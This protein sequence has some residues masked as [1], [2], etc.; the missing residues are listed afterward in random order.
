VSAV[1]PTYNRA[2]LLPQALDSVLHQTRPPDRVIVVDDGSTDGTE[3]VLS[4]YGQKIE[5]LS[6]PNS[7]KSTAL[8][9][10]LQAIDGGWVWLFDDDDLA[11]PDAIDLHLARLSETP[12]AFF[13]FSARTDLFTDH[14]GNVQACKTVELP[15]FPEHE[16]LPALLEN[17]FFS[18]QGAL[19]H[20]SCFKQIRFREDLYR[21]MDYEFMLRLVRR[22]PGVRLDR[23]TFY[24]R[25]HAGLRG[26]ASAR[27]AVSDVSQH[28]H[29][30]EQQFFS[31]LYHELDLA[32]YVGAPTQD[33]SAEVAD[34]QP[35]AR[36]KRGTV[37]ARKGL[38][39][40]ALADFEA[41]AGSPQAVAA[42]TGTERRQ[43]QR[44][45]ERDYPLFDLLDDP[46]L[47]RRFRRVLQVLCDPADRLAVARE[48]HFALA[49]S[50]SRIGFRRRLR[51]A[52][53]LISLLGWRGSGRYAMLK[54][55]KL[56]PT[57]FRGSQMTK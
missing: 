18:L 16:I 12:G 35:R 55:R 11:Y 1:I 7:G 39:H 32:E 26:P 17:A 15:E 43:L 5:V 6:Q 48:M 30:N 49:R 44:V 33:V 52:W 31:E 28:W 45:V 42:I 23:P 10:A 21:A 24:A 9:L 22:F 34:T 3:Q 29:L 37:M 46:A 25:R 53:E 54:L 2:E 14:D 50:K 19:I 41:V 40:L 47:V 51:Q 27:F 13:S 36:L 38:W 56:I 57:R 20:A 4:S 8:N